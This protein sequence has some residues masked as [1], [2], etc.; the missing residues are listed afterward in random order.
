MGYESTRFIGELNEEFYCSICTMILEEPM[1]S[2]CDHVFCKEC[3]K[4]W[5]ATD[6]SCPIDRS[7]LEFDHLKPAVRFFCNML[8]GFEMKCDFRK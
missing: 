8:D 2:P 4:A 5:L 1:Q 7:S 3:I 6:G